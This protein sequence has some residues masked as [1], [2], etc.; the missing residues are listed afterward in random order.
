M[1][2]G[3]MICVVL[4]VLAMSA[5]AFQNRLQGQVRNRNN[6]P[7]PQC[8]IDFKQ[9]E[10]TVYRVYSDQRGIFY[11]DAPVD[12]QYVVVVSQGGRSVSLNANIARATLQPSVLYVPW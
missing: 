6:A 12:G 11:L 1:R 5:L 3:A 4:L 7:A 2:R 9:G 10:Q 8:Q